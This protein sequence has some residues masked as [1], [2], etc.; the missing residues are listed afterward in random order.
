MVALHAHY[1]SHYPRSHDSPLTQ[2]REIAIMQHTAS[3]LYMLA[4]V[5]FRLMSQQLKTRYVYTGAL[6]VLN[7]IINHRVVN[8]KK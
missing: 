5:M 8:G 1:T 2:I 3:S 7:V 6:K 4:L